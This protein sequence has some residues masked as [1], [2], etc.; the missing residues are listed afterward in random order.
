MWDTLP[1]AALAGLVGAVAGSFCATAALRFATGESPWGGRSRCDGCARTLGWAETVPFVGFVRSGGQCPACHSPIDRMHLWGEGLG[2]IVAVTAIV[3]SPDTSGII[4][5]LVGLVLLVLGLAD[6]RTYRLPDLGNAIVA[7]LCALLAL[8]RHELIIGLIAAATTAVLLFILKVWLERRR[9]RTM[10]GTGDI[11]LIAALAVG[12][13]AWTSYMIAGAAM[14]GLGAIIIRR[15]KGHDRL[16]FG[17]FIA[18][19]GFG[20][21]LLGGLMGAPV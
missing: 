4:L 21:L 11:K 12:L 1:L 13:G 9:G 10:L 7:A 19:S 3:T 2:A 16:P 14:F 6:I 15:M 18:A 5:A 20:C 17:P 8:L